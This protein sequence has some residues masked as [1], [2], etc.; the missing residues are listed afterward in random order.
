M[1]PISQF[2][3]R[4]GLRK[5]PVK[6]MRSMCTDIA[7]TNNSAAQAVDLPHQQ[8]AADLEGEVERDENA[9]DMWMPRGWCTRLR[10]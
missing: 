4:S 10:T 6:K 1:A 9:S 2:N 7:A 3:S 8:T 5:A